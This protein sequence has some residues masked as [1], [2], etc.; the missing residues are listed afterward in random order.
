MTCPLGVPGVLAVKYFTDEPPPFTI[1][2]HRCFRPRPS[3]WKATCPPP[4][5]VPAATAR[6]ASPKACWAKWCSA[7]FAWTSLLPRP[8][9]PPRPPPAP[10]RRPSSCAAARPQAI[11]ARI[12]AEPEQAPLLEVEAEPVLVRADRRWRPHETG[13]GQDR[14]T[15]RPC[16]PHRRDPR[17]RSCS[18]RPNGRRTDRRRTHPAP[19]AAAARFRGRR[20]PGCATSERIVSSS[21]SR[22]ARSN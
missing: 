5:P 12:Q 17:S 4:S 11:A 10:P 13:A 22:A 20:R 21:P 7:P 18:P 2:Q 19:N 15:T 3:R 9:P 16:L 1:N 8:T 14:R 6:C